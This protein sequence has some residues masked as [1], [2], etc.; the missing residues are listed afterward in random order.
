MNYDDWK[1]MTHEEDKGLVEVDYAVTAK[2]SADKE[3]FERYWKTAKGVSQIEYCNWEDEDAYAEFYF[4][5]TTSIWTHKRA[6]DDEIK[7]RIEEDA[8][9]YFKDG[10]TIEYEI[11]DYYKKPSKI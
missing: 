1:L 3:S 7:E 2:V 6:D 9:E 10:T 4:K 8:A 5:Y 11:E